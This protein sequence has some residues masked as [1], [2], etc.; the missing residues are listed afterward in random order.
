M[1]VAGQEP[2][3]PPSTRVSDTGRHY[4]DKQVALILKRAAEMQTKE[5]PSQGA[6]GLSLADLEQIALEAGLDPEHVRLAAAEV[7]HSGH[8]GGFLTG[9]LGA[10]RQ[11]RV[12]RIV[13]QEVPDDF[14]DDLLAEIQTA[15]IGH[16]NASL[17]GR[18]LTWKMTGTGQNADTAIITIT[19]RDGRTEL[20]AERNRSGTA[21]GLMAG[22]AGGGGI[23]MG[24]GIGLPLGLE[25]LGSPLA[26]VLIP[27]VIAGGLYGLAR[28][29]F[30]S[31]HRSHRQKFD[32]LLN[33]MS[34]AIEAEV[35][36]R[37]ESVD[38]ASLPRPE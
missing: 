30:A 32:R 26:A 12:H 27:T 11:V 13:N 22:L 9:L 29:I 19:S 24:V 34:E 23:G 5:R 4:D 25:A 8:E 15:G 33:R 35:G 21:V 36:R 16:G 37:L 18:T 38:P 2:P 17:V 31:G 1:G 14:F 20:H 10:P 7:D 6:S 28:T 3:S